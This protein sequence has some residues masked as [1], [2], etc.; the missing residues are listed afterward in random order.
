[1]KLRRAKPSARKKKLGKQLGATA[2][3]DHVKADPHRRHFDSAGGGGGGG[4]GS[5]GGGGGRMGE[6]GGGWGGG[7]T[8]NEAQGQ[9]CAARAA[10]RLVPKG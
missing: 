6:V 5:R 7:C 10:S 4:G 3:D 2:A 8:L 9:T 1:M